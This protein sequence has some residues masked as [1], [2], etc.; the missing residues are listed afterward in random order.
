MELVF[1]FVLLLVK[2]ALCVPLIQV[3]QQIEVLSSLNG[4]I[5]NSTR[6][7]NVLA[8]A[9][10][11]TLLAPSDTAFDK[12]LGQSGTPKAEADIE[13]TLLYHL[14]HGGFPTI[15]ITAVPQFAS[16]NLPN[17]VVANVTGGQVVEAVTDSTGTPQ[18]LSGNKTASTISSAVRYTLEA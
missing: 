17:G 13:E 11:F 8:T 6:L 15:G 2:Y 3:L 4:Y 5:A 16:S 12:W 1:F 14:L 7:T 18:F 10:N 9:D